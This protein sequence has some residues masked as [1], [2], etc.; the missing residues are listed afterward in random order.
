MG[1]QQSNVTVLSAQEKYEQGY[2]E[3]CNL[4]STLT[5]AE[6]EQQKQEVFQSKPGRDFLN[7]FTKENHSYD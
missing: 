6:R 7:T 2:E 1:K 5:I 4:M 3:F